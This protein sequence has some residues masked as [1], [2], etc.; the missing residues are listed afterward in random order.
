MRW[1]DGQRGSGRY[2]VQKSAPWKCHNVPPSPARYAWDAHHQ[3]FGWE[4]EYQK[5]CIRRSPMV[6]APALRR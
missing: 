6:C 3:H 2:E 4:S 5:K 1:Q